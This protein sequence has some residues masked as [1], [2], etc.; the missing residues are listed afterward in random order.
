MPVNKSMSRFGTASLSLA[1][2]SLFLVGNSVHAQT[3]HAASQVTLHARRIS[4]LTALRRICDQAHMRY[5][6]R[7]DA[8]AIVVNDDRSGLNTAVDIDNMPADHAIYSL[9]RQFDFLDT[10]TFDRGT[11]SIGRKAYLFSRGNAFDSLRVSIDLVDIPL[12][13]ALQRICDQAGVNYAFDLGR[14]EQRKVSL[15]LKVASIRDGVNAILEKAQASPALEFTSKFGMV[16]VGH[17]FASYGT[18]ETI[19]A[20][21]TDPVYLKCRQENLYVA[22]WAVANATGQAFTLHEEYKKQ[23]VSLT[24]SKAPLGNALLSLGAHGHIAS[25]VKSDGGVLTILPQHLKGNWISNCPPAY[26]PEKQ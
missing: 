25:V 3:K 26:I 19:R 22:A 11:D 5:Q 10:I 2:T 21:L 6:F 8:A 9:L 17:Q 20:R 15:S 24:L 1:L 16:V 18:D 14:F 7:S 23:N 12:V 13:R 4:F